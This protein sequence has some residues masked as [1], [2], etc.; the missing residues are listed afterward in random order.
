MEKQLDLLLEEV[1]LRAAL[2]PCYTN[3]CLPRERKANV[4]YYVYLKRWMQDFTY[5]VQ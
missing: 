2:F 5:T 1:L 3:I 4:Y